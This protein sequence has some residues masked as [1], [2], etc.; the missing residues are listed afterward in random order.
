MATEP[1]GFSVR[2]KRYFISGLIAFLPLALTINLL[3][4]MFNFAD[5]LLGIYVEPYLLKEFGFYVKGLSILLCLFIILLLGFTINNFL[6]KTLYANFETFLLNLPFFKQIYPALKEILLF[7]FSKKKLSFK[8]V[9][10]VEYPRKGV[11]AMGFYTNETHRKIT[12]KTPEEEL[13]N[14]FIPHTPSPF[15]GFLVMFP[16]KDIIILDISIEEALKII[17]SAGVIN[18]KDEVGKLNLHDDEKM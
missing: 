7:L 8:K 1:N 4:L 13:C 11:Y 2:I 9:V 16:K 6:G 10:L 18:S 3:I 14:V 15:G 12:S 17:V 5:R